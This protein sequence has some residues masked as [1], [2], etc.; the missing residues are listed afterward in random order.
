MYT[1][2]ELLVR[3]TTKLNTPMDKL[4]P[5]EIEVFNNICWDDE[6]G[7]YSPMLSLTKDELAE[8]LNF[9]EEQGT[10]YPELLDGERWALEDVF[11]GRI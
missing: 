8:F 1:S 4:S 11:T 5:I 9:V 7:R 3:F 10:S 6:R 2:S